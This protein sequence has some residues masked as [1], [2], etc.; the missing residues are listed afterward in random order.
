MK[1]IP[2]KIVFA[3]KSKMW[4]HAFEKF[5]VKVYIPTNELYTD[6]INYGFV[7]PYLLVFEEE[8]Y[9][10]EEAKVFADE[11][12]LSKI[13][14]DFGGSVVFV[15]PSNEGGWNKAPNDLFASIISESKISQYYEDG[16]AIMW[17]R[18][19]KKWGDCFIRGA[20]LRTC[21]YSKGASADYIAK[22]CLKSIEGDG[23]FGKGDITPVACIL[24]GL[25]VLPDVQRR[26][27]PVV[28]VANSDE[29]NSIL[30]AGTDYL[31]VKDKAEYIEDFYHF[32]KQYRRMVGNLQIEPDFD[33]MG[34]VVEPSYCVVTTSKDNQGDDAQ[35]TEHKVGYVAYYNKELMEKNNK[36]PLVLCFHGGGDSA[37]FMSS[38]SGWSLIAAKYN[39]LLVCIENHLNS[40]AT[41]MMELL[42]HLKG[43]YNIDDEKIYSTGFSMGGCKS[44]DMY[45]EYSQ[46]FAA[47][48]PMDAT[49]EVGLNAY[50]QAAPKV[51]QD[52][53]VPVFYA[54]GEITPLP[55]LPFQAQKCVDRM[56]YVMKINQSKKEYSVDFNYQKSWENPI[57]GIDGD[58]ICELKDTS[59]GS[60]L[61]LHLFES[62]NGCCYCVFGSIS[63]QGHEV[64]HHTCEQAW[65][66]M[67]QFKRLSNGELI[68]GKIEDIV[69]L[70]Q[71]EGNK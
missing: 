9:T 23:L 69:K 65:L 5:E 3:D 35:T 41:E 13:A 14:A 54:G 71:E 36:L 22:N 11:T 1:S 15:Y 47:V 52:V 70:Y 58:V 51:N 25:S 63:G 40:T 57:W 61:T 17:D 67:N 66:F 29:V 46:I 34:M 68:G 59:R 32:L 28:S 60:V 53:I 38:V 45:Q 43:K 10:K 49:F 2:E 30:Q 26:D 20:I 42:V 16:V 55:E 62:N 39:F 24:E 27:I 21:L 7:A 50:G 33:K 37:M 56:A 64:R 4:E 48:A 6:V 12:G 18:F 8:K 19:N 31:L 44:W